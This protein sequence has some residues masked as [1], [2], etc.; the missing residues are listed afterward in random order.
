M[1][2]NAPI[3]QA[4]PLDNTNNS[5]KEIIATEDYEAFLNSA[6]AKGPSGYLK[7]DSASN[8]QEGYD[9]KMATDQ[10][11]SCLLRLGEP[12]SYSYECIGEES[13]QPLHF[14]SNCDAELYCT[15]KEAS[16]LK[17]QDNS[18]QSDPLLK[19]N[20]RTFELQTASKVTSS[21]ESTKEKDQKEFST[22]GCI[23]GGIGIVAVGGA[24]I[25][26]CMLH[27]RTYERV[28]THGVTPVNGV[29]FP[30]ENLIHPRETSN[31][32]HM[33]TPANLTTADSNRSPVI[34]QSTTTKVT[35][36]PE[37]KPAQL[38]G[39]IVEDTTS[40][41]DSNN[42]NAVA[43]STNGILRLGP[44]GKTWQR[45]VNGATEDFVHDPI[46]ADHS[47]DRDAQFL[48]A[49]IRNTSPIEWLQRDI[50]S[51]QEK[52]LI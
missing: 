11:S 17:P 19:T 33:M 1:M 9:E 35:G 51:F 27:S 13:L 42:R 7:N 20:I 10:E 38:G 37:R 23:L 15:W 6:E 29:D 47:K 26:E 3:L 34:N 28:N 14:I 18:S 31:K 43:T 8:S 50:G 24:R 21:P 48:G 52:K 40:M 5:N 25:R 16:L 32:N 44:D 22:F 41:T 46:K 45:C 2:G 36:S 30:Q 12:G 4:A 39:N 49:I